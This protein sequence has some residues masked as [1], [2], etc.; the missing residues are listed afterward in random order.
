MTNGEKCSW[1]S[2]PMLGTCSFSVRPSGEAALL[3]EEALDA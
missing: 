3:V 2:D 1:S